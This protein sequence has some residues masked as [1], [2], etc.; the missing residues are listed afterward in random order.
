MEA[1][2]P[3]ICF[4]HNRSD[5]LVTRQ[6]GHTKLNCTTTKSLKCD[7]QCQNY[8]PNPVSSSPVQVHARLQ[9]QDLTNTASHLHTARSIPAIVLH[10]TQ[11]YP[12]LYLHTVY[13]HKNTLQPCSQNSAHRGPVDPHARS[14]HGPREPSLTS[15]LKTRSASSATSPTTPLTMAEGSLYPSPRTQWRSSACPTPTPCRSPR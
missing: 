9:L 13:I 5:C 11:D 3:T 14:L 10:G 1:Y 6:V 7:V 4:G 2:V 8:C 15:P 12:R